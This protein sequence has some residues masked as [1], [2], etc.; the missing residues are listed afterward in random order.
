[1]AEYVVY[2]NVDQMRLGTELS[3]ATTFAGC[4]FKRATRR[5]NGSVPLATLLFVGESSF[6]EGDLARFLEEKLRRSTMCDVYVI[7]FQI[8]KLRSRSTLRIAPVP[9]NMASSRS[10]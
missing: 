4:G 1:M 6:G 5:E 2:V 3:V 10:A 7:V 9:I 8:A